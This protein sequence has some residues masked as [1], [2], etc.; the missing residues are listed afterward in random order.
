MKKILILGGTRYVGLELIKLL[1][2]KK[3]DLFIASRRKIDHKKFIFLDRKN[4]DNL[5]EI[6][7]KHE[8]D[9]VVDF[10]CYSSLDSKKLLDSLKINNRTPKLIIISS[11]YVYSDPK[12]INCNSTFTEDCFISTNFGYSLS[13]LPDISYSKGK[14]EMESYIS[15]HYDQDKLVIIRFPIVL[16]SNDYTNRTLFYFSLIKNKSKFNPKKINNISNYIFSYEASLSIFNFIDSNEYGTFNIA[17]KEVSEYDL[18]SI[19]CEFF[20]INIDQI[21]DSNIRQS[22]SPFHINYDFK[23][24]SSKYNSIFGDKTN[25]KNNLLRELSKINLN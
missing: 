7:S 23:I 25:F 16:G 12:K 13:D 22:K 14:R 18:I 11:V 6:F 5:N 1:N 21:I 24:D 9:I 4:I 15:Q 3:I 19:Y 10:I 17:S 2:K 20:K 8:F